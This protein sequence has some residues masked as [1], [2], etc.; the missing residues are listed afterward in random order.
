MAGLRINQPF[1]HVSNNRFVCIC[2][3]IV[4]NNSNLFSETK[5]LTTNDDP[6]YIKDGPTRINDNT[7][8]VLKCRA[9]NPMH[10]YFRWYKNG[11]LIPNTNTSSNR[12]KFKSFEFGDD[13]SYECK[14]SD[15]G[16]YFEQATEPRNLTAI[17][18]YELCKCP[19]PPGIEKMNMTAEKLEERVK[20]IEKNLTVT[21]RR[22]SKWTRKKKT[23]DN[24]SGTALYCGLAITIP[25]FCL[26]FSFIV[27]FDVLTLCRQI[28]NLFKGKGLQGVDNIP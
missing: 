26:A 28:Y 20:E 5:E 25:V 13:G 24:V 11:E 9:R 12:L 16:L 8:L 27:S 1:N 21:T 2:R 4:K 10:N 6:P 17:G 23:A 19:C 18:R 3:C 14:A 7:F 22:M 15:R